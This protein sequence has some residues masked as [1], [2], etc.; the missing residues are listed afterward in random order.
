ML[1]V[2]DGGGRYSCSDGC[3][4]LWRWMFQHSVLML[5]AMVVVV[6]VVAVEVI[7][8]DS[9]GGGVLG[10]VVDFVGVGAGVEWI[11][12]SSYCLCVVFSI[13]ILILLLLWQFINCLY[14]YILD[15]C[16]I[17]I[18]LHYQIIIDI[19]DALVY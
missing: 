19:H 18:W 5:V 16:E 14:C 7:V 1:D 9:S 4:C 13:S 10:I 6:N 12:H 15:L 11:M 2:F 3:L 8:V 17:V